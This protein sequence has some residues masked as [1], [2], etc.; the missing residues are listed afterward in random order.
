MA[1]DATADSC[2]SGDVLVAFAEGHLTE[3]ALSLT[4]A[5]IDACATCQATLQ[6]FGELSQIGNPV[7]RRCSRRRRAVAIPARPATRARLPG[8]RVERPR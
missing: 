7:A 5:H 2:P 8:S 6:L 3:P 1:T 4:E